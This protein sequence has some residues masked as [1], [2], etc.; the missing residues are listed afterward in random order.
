MKKN[1]KKQLIMAQAETLFSSGG[2]QNT[3]I[4]QIARA[5]SISEASIYEHF[6]NKED[7]LFSIPEKHF[8]DLLKNLQEHLLGV[9]GA[10]NKVRKLIWQY[11]LFVQER[12]NFI[13][14]FMLH[15]WSNQRFY[16]SEKRAKL[17]EYWAFVYT[18]LKEAR[19][20]GVFRHDID[21]LVCECM[22]YGTINHYILTSLVFDRPLNLIDKGEILDRLF[23]D[24][25]C[26]DTKGRDSMWEGNGKKEVILQAA[27]E[28]FDKEGYLQT[29][30]AQ[31]C[32]R[33]G[34]TEPTLYE[35]FKGKEEILLAIPEM[36]MD[37]FLQ[38]I[39][40]HIMRND[41]PDS[42]LKLLLW[43]QINSYEAYPDYYRVLLSELHCNPKF[44]Q[45]AAYTVGRKY[46]EE[47]MTILKTGVDCGIF[48]KDI[49]LNAIQHVYFGMFD[50][51]LLYSMVRP[52][53]LKISEKMS[54]IY[55]VIMHM[56]RVSYA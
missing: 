46:A 12:P 3:T 2:F 18:I 13:R 48:R 4:T 31:I 5:C 42:N 50:Q 39:K 22:I 38:D 23:M 37:K 21:L 29:T 53:E 51:L 8:Q 56:I 6:K 47:L 10:E 40:N 30:I 15:V 32:R 19:D 17:I 55:D 26:A 45:S 49:N 36:A 54:K 52:N 20:E 33:A 34:I 43:N 25:M 1:A 35:Y 28:E 44:Y 24:A 16:K 11:L 7:L 14:L 27:L 41:Q 9:Y